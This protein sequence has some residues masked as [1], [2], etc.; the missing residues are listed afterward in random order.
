MLDLIIILII[1]NLNSLSLIQI[2]NQLFYR[3]QNWYRYSFGYNDNSFPPD[4]SIRYLTDYRTSLS[5]PST[6]R[7]QRSIVNPRVT[8]ILLT[9]IFFTLVYSYY[10]LSFLSI[11]NINLT[12]VYIISYI[13]LYFLLFYSLEFKQYFIFYFIYIDYVFNSQNYYFILLFL[14]TTI[15]YY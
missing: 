4:H 10:L 14:L 2:I 13:L 12:I 9:N 11:I 5:R 8:L 3:L 7:A 6:D 15:L 1:V